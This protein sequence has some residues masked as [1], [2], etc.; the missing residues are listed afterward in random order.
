[1]F[2]YLR[3]INY[4]VYNQHTRVDMCARIVLT[5]LRVNR[6]LIQ[7]KHDP[8]I[9]NILTERNSLNFFIRKQVQ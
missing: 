1:M 6:H 4:D 8:D 7:S 2:D 3:Y 9:I 5:I